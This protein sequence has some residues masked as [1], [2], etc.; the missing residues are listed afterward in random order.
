MHFRTRK[1][2]IFQPAI[3]VYQFPLL[4][5]YCPPSTA[6]AMA[7][8]RYCWW[9]RNPIPNHLGCVKPIVNIGINYHINWWAGFLNHQQYAI[10]DNGFSDYWRDEAFNFHFCKI[11]APFDKMR[12]TATNQPPVTRNL[13]ILRL[14]FQSSSINLLKTHSPLFVVLTNPQINTDHSCSHQFPNYHVGVSKNNGTPKSSIKNR[15]F[16]YFHHPFWGT[17]IFGNTHVFF[18]PPQKPSFPPWSNVS[19]ATKNV[20]V[21]H[22]VLSWASIAS[23]VPRKRYWRRRVR[24]K[25]GA[26]NSK[27]RQS[28]STFGS[29]KIS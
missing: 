14:W 22:L 20:H 26:K 9:F 27:L 4:C 19:P 7:C 12:E 25:G 23:R 3:L 2:L 11:S 8:V 6:M 28:F 5:S 17:P 29:L 21:G 16:H 10:V 15:V 24:C 1:W 13:K 18:S